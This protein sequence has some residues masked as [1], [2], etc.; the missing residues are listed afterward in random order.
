MRAIEQGLPMIRVANTGVSAMINARGQIV[1]QLGL[2]EAGFIDATLPAKL[3]PTV[4]AKSGD[5][6]IILLIA[7]SLIA[8]IA[9]K[10]PVSS[11]KNN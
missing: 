3:P 7:L 4:Y 5:V 9:G 2:G 11:L 6:P 8:L 1:A 10:L